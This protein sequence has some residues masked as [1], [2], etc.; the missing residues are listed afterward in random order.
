MFNPQITRFIKDLFVILCITVV[1]LVGIEGILRLVFPEKIKSV[2]TIVYEHNKDFLVNL[3]PNVTKIFNRNKENG[4]KSIH[5]KTN[6]DS[7]RGAELKSNPDLRVIVYGDSNIQARFSDLENTYTGQLELRLQKDGLQNIEVLNA[8]IIGFGPDQSLIRFSK[9]VDKYRPDLVVF[10][11]FADNDFGDII[12]N[13]LFDL[14]DDGRLTRTGHK[15][16]VD[17]NL[18]YNESY[19]SFTSRL[20]IMRAINKISSHLFV[21]NEEQGEI[22]DQLQ[23]ANEAEYSIYKQLQPKKYSHFEDHYDV[24]IAIDPFSESSREKTLLMTEVLKE[25]NNIAKEKSVRFLVVI[26]PSAT[27][28]TIDNKRLSYK[29]LERYSKY[30]RENLTKIVEDICISYKIKYINLFD[31]FLRNEPDTLFF[32]GIDNHW[33]DKGQE[34]AAQQT[35]HY[36]IKNSMLE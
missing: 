31:I 4:G 14:N 28:L 19:K 33:N 29:S 24:D 9:E 32:T 23:R 17:Q 7:F 25:A 27:D 15:I 8:G 18:T 36:L 2:K 11:I 6:S 10:H 3:K 12:R 13:R 34:I 26:Q 16:T 21:R 5:W 22:I 35:A 30:K 20:L 1:V